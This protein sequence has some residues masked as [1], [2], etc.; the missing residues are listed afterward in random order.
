[1]SPH[2]LLFYPIF[3]SKSFPLSFCPNLYCLFCTRKNVFLY[4]FHMKIV[5]HV[6]S[7]SFVWFC[8]FYSVCSLTIYSYIWCTLLTVTLH[9]IWMP[10]ATFNLLPTNPFL[11]FMP[12]VWIISGYYSSISIEDFLIFCPRILVRYIVYY[13]NA[14]NMCY[15]FII[16]FGQLPSDLHIICS[17]KYFYFNMMRLIKSHFHCF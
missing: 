8:K 16:S 9:F 7:F 10:P 1:M 2:F 3:I 17:L 5:W 13:P 14:S 6:F 11:P 12:F 4:G 15:Q